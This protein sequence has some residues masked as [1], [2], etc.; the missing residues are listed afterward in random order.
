MTARVYPDRGSVSVEMAILTPAF[1]LLIVFGI[2]SGRVAVAYN[3]IDLAA[4]DAARAASISRDAGTAYQQ[5]RAAAFD[6]LARQGL[7]CIDES[8]NRPLVAVDTRGFSVPVGQSASVSATI[9][10]TVSFADVALPGVPRTRQLS[11]TFVSPLD[12]YRTRS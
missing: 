2:V 6:T 1:L 3:A 4:H 8:G 7:Q 9:T 11:S 10:C 5:G 12:T